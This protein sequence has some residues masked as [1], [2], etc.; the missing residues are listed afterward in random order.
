MERKE[1]MPQGF[2]EG[3]QKLGKNIDKIHYL[4]RHAKDLR[5]YRIMIENRR[6]D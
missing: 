3:L 6:Y 4:T 5:I 1:R 2:Q